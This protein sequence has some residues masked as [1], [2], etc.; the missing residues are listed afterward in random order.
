MPSVLKTGMPL[1]D[2]SFYIYEDNQFFCRDRTP[3]LSRKFELPRPICHCCSK[4]RQSKPSPIFVPTIDVS[5]NT[6]AV[7]CS[8]GVPQR[9][10]NFGPYVYIRCIFCTV[11][12]NVIWDIGSVSWRLKAG[13]LISYSEGCSG[14]EA[15]AYAL[16]HFLGCVLAWNIE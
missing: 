6:V 15:K 1:S 13:T 11:R 4:N 10:G 3:C 9:T 8:Q 12:W 7:W 16:G 14:N 5:E 2:I